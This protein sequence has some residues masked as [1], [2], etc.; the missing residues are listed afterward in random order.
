MSQIGGGEGVWGGPDFFGNF[1]I[2]SES[3][4]QAQSIG[5]LFGQIG[6]RGGTVD[7]SN[8]QRHTRLGAGRGVRQANGEAIHSK[9]PG[10]CQ[11]EI[12]RKILKKWKQCGTVQARCG[13]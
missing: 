3:S 13:W 4:A 7:M 12:V 10:L 1:N 2:S 6:L 11:H 9:L 5:T 8:S